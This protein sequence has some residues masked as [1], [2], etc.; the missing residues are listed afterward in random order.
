MKILFVVP[1]GYKKVGGIYLIVDNYTRIFRDKGIDIEVFECP[2]GRKEKQKLKEYKERMSRVIVDDSY[3]VVM[4]YALNLS[5]ETIRVLQSIQF[6]GKKICFMV[7]SMTLYS[8]SLR[9]YMSPGKEK[10]KELLKKC[11]YKRKERRCIAYYD[12]VVYV[13]EVD[14]NYAKNLFPKFGDK[15]FC[16][17]NGT[18]IPEEESYP[19][20]GE[21]ALGMLTG[22]SE[23][24]IRNNVLPFMN[25]IL[26]DIHN[27]FPQIRFVLAG[28]GAPDWFKEKIDKLNYAHYLGFVEH[29]SSFY[30]EIDAAVIT[31]RK[32]CGIINRVLEAWAFGKPAIGFKRNFLAF[33]YAEN[34]KHYYAADTVAEFVEAIEKMMVDNRAKAMGEEARR[35]VEQ[36]YTW[37]SSSKELL[38]LI[39]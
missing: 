6:S 38:S 9:K 5:F 34:G 7:D 4:T 36:R 31:V 15:L 27:R 21:F 33:A 37:E 18:E 1:E 11:L 29:L 24:T 12:K 23:E 19:C 8:E 22:F 17:P 39:N 10:T 32:E 25:D 13:S 3:D 16:V 35:L 2:Y 30:S 20:E 14:K 28:R 26:P